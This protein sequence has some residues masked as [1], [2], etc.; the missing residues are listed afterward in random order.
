MG[1]THDEPLDAPHQRR[2]VPGPS[3][4]PPPGTAALVAGRRRRRGRRVWRVLLGVVALLIVA[5]VVAT[6]W[7]LSEYAITPGQAINVSTMVGLPASVAHRHTGRILM[8]DVDLVQLRAIDYL[9]YRLNGDD[10]VLPASA[11]FGTASSTQYDAQGTVDMTN[12]EQAATVVALR[13]LGYPVR[14]VPDGI[15]VYQPISGSPAAGVLRIGQVISAID[16]RATDTPGEVGSALSGL[17]PG[18][19]ATLTVHPLSTSTPRH[20]VHLR[21][22]E[23]TDQGTSCAPVRAA[24]PVASS[25]RA[26]IGFAFEPAYRTV[27]QPFK[28]DISSEGIIGPSAGLAFTLGLIAKLDR[29]SLTDGRT[30]AAT[31]TMSVTGQ[32]GDVGGVAQ[33]TVA[34]ERGGA[35]VFFVPVPE[36]KVAKAHADSSLRVIAVSSAAQ[37][38][39]DL[40]KM[41]GRL[42]AR[43][44]SR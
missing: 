15:I 33:K 28:V 43:A 34:V 14:A 10:E 31:G 23:I 22:G 17:R 42:A 20:E 37:A 6:F 41:G 12:A 2:S 4:W 8:T 13:A 29:S 1:R 40:E 16:G 44:T 27:G 9:Y 25:A 18:S 35:T 21:L 38:I 30:I 19:E 5:A 7:P 3:E 26:C 32:V 36:Y 11:L 24:Q 39:S